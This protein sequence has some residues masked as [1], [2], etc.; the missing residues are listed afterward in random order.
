MVFKPDNILLA[1]A[2][3]VLVAL[4]H[5]PRAVA[6]SWPIEGPVL[7]PFVAG[8]DPYAGGQHRGIDIGAPTGA[9]VRAPATGIVSF[10]YTPMTTPVG[11]WR[12]VVRCTFG[13]ETL[14][15]SPTFTVP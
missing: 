6:W 8:D 15:T 10:T 11:T 12:N 7:R 4:T 1:L 13:S 5:V 14:V 9:D 2:A 3:V